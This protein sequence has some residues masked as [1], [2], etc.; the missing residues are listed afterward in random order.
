MQNIINILDKNGRL[1]RQIQHPQLM[2]LKITAIAE[3]TRNNELWIGAEQSDQGI[4]V[5]DMHKD[6]FTV[7]RKI[8][9]IKGNF[10]LS[11]RDRGNL[12]SWA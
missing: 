7:K 4:I 3:I 2:N 8:Q 12:D 9:K 6:A 11:T 5:L 10:S 1:L